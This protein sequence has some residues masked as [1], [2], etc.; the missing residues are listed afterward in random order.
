MC[1]S[2]TGGW[3]LPGVMSDY[4]HGVY[5]VLAKY[6]RCRL[7]LDWCWC[8]CRTST[9][10]RCQWGLQVWRRQVGLIRGTRW[11]AESSAGRMVAKITR[12]SLG[13]FLGWASIL[14]SIRDYVGAES[15]V[16]IRKGYTEFAGFQWFTR[17]PLGS[18]VDPQSQERRIEYRG[19]AA[20]DRSDRWVWPVEDW[21]VC[22][23]AVWR[24]RSGGHASE[25][26][27]LH[28]G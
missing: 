7:R 4:Q 16:V 21:P 15:W 27:G 23:D 22:D 9:K 12:G 17:K 25:S 13:R 20:S 26:Q 14:R 6:C 1:G 19:A 28:R 10:G 3:L 18:W 5:W 11:P 24:L 8:R 2:R